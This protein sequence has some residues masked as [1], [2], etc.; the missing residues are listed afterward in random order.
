MSRTAPRYWAIVPAAGIG[1]RMGAVLPKQYLQL[2]EKTVIEQT[3]LRL[4]SEKRLE[5]IVVAISQN[6]T[7]WESVKQNFSARVQTT[8]GGRE[9]FESVLSGLRYLAGQADNNDWVLVHDAARPCVTKKEIGRLIERLKADP[10][11]GILALPVHDTL[12]K[13]Q[14][15]VV[16]STL[17]RQTIWRA[18]TPQMFRFGLL[19]KALEQ[20]VEAGIAVTDEASAIESLGYKPK[21]VEGEPENIKITRPADLALAAFYLEKKV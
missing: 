9:R 17:D 3:L 1:S 16:E 5:T 15:G 13:V 11:G 7:C 14:Q 12:K 20:A 8:V 21:L 2:A 6:D 10:V 18:L 19:K 4:L